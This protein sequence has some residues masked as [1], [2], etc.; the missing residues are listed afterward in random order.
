[1]TTSLHWAGGPI[2][3]VSPAARG[4]TTV[5]SLLQLGTLEAEEKFDDELAN[6]TAYLCYSSGESTFKLVHAGLRSEVDHRYNREAKGCRGSKSQQLLDTQTEILIIFP[7]DDAQKPYFCPGPS[8]ASFPPSRLQYRQ[9]AR[10]ASLL[11]H[12]WW[13]KTTPK[14]L[15]FVE[16]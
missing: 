16:R 14:H 10:S 12:L 11:S 1:M 5:A 9:G 3:P 6:E 8:Q 4:L 7:L 13:V 15:F 2:I